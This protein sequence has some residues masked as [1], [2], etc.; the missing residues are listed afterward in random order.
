MKLTTDHFEGLDAQLA[1][2]I[3]S[4][5]AGGFHETA[6]LLRMARL[7]LR[8]R[9]YGITPGELDALLYFLRRDHDKSAKVRPSRFAEN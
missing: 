1:A 8:T 5:A 3:D 2:L 6:A 7:D 4:V 9:A